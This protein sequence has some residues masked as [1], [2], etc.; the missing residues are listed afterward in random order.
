M[1]EEKFFFNHYS[2]TSENATALLSS[3]IEGIK[4]FYLKKQLEN[5]VFYFYTEM[6]SFW[7]FKID[8]NLSMK[9][10]FNNLQAEYQ[11]FFIDF[12]SKSI[13]IKNIFENE[14]IL[15]Q[16]PNYDIVIKGDGSGE[17]Y[18]LFV[19]NTD[20]NGVLL[21]FNQ[22]TWVESLIEVCKVE[23]NKYIDIKL[24][25][26]AK[27]EHA[28]ELLSFEEEAIKKAI[29]EKLPNK[30]IVYSKSF[31]NWLLSYDSSSIEKIINKISEAE[32]NN[33][34]ID[35]FLVKSINQNI[36]Q[37]KIG[38]QGGLQQ[39]AIRVLFIKN[40][41]RIYILHGFVKQGGSTYD[42]TKDINIT[43]QL[44]NDIEQE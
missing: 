15:N 18:Y 35:G 26:I 10:V 36:W 13:E 4:F 20:L 42:Y 16:L 21:S 34:N 9:D 8:D 22:G 24:K 7:D 43:N 11:S 19:L 33:F 6:D 38:T 31:Q 14:E 32:K 44:F 2:L 30:N 28:I 40:N 12:I 1:N 25:N 3:L 41:S 39:S 17:Q 29:L 37:I 27:R 5:I 23:D